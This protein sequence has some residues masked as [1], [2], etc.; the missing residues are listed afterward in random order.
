MHTQGRGGGGGLRGG[1]GGAVQPLG[2]V[3]N[4]G[5]ASSG[6]SC[7]TERGRSSSPR[8]SRTEMEA[9]A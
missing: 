3:D 7:S 1:A 5:N 4:H 6:P 2:E 9:R 8:A